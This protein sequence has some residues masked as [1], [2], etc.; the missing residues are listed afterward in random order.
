MCANWDNAGYAAREVAGALEQTDLPIMSTRI[1]YSRRVASATLAKRPVVLRAPNSS[2][3]EAY[4]QLADEV[5]AAYHQVV[6]A[7]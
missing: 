3:A 2:V 1:P 4:E 7:A 6:L 5:L